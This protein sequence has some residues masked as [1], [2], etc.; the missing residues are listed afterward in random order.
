VVKAIHTLFIGLFCKL[1][2]IF[3]LLFIT[4]TEP[5]IGEDQINLLF[6]FLQ[7]VQ[8]ESCSHSAFAFAS[9]DLTEN[10]F[11]VIK[12]ASVEQISGN[13]II[14]DRKLNLSELRLNMFDVIYISRL[15]LLVRLV[16]FNKFVV[17]F[18]EILRITKLFTDLILFAGLRP[19]IERLIF[20]IVLPSI[21]GN[22]SL[23]YD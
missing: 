9:S 2:K 13:L 8:S 10:S 17:S 19:F 23:H 1:P 3:T 18:V 12:D 16:D 11:A 14:V 5:F 22:I 7:V 4:I 6:S 21:I 15:M 20:I